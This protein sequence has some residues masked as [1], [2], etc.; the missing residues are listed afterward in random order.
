VFRFSSEL[1]AGITDR[2]LAPRIPTDLI[3]KPSAVMFWARMGSLNALEMS[4]QSSFWKCWLG[5]PL[6]SADTMGMVYSKMDA[7]TLRDAQHQVYAQL[8]RNK[9]LPDNRGISLAIVD[10]H[11]SHASYRQHCP[12]CLERTV[13][14]DSGDRTQY[15]HRQVTLILVTGAPA[16][17]QPLRILL[18]LEPQRPGED[19]VATAKRLLERVIYSYPRAF[20][21]V[22]ADALYARADFFNFLLDHRKHALVVLKDERRNLY[23]DA[24]GMFA[25]VQPVKG[26][27]R[28]CD[29]LWWDFP[30]LSSWP[31]VNTPVR[32]IRSLETR[33]VKRQL[34]KK[35]E[36]LISDWIWVT[37]LPA[38]LVDAKRGAEF[39]HQRWDIENYGFNELVNGWHTDHVMK[40]D[41]NAMECFLLM[42]FLAFNIYH[43]FIYLNLKP[44]LRAGKSKEYWAK[45]MAAEV[46]SV[47]IPTA[48]SP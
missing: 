32:V 15:Y 19:E 41:S 2:R 10:G 33:S 8:K 30:D 43:A 4:G 20:D 13:H 23:Q 27:Y 6:P 28:S 40:H 44:A 18:D 34:D 17:R 31:E 9:A 3:A 48:M 5:G 46:Y 26:T 35:R 7:A 25:L 47:L 22:L 37:T 29:C 24:A 14:L 11:E 38:D 42:A 45:L 39:G 21:L 16:N 36:T 12:G 1:I